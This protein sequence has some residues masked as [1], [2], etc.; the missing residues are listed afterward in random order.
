[1]ERVPFSLLRAAYEHARDT[2]HDNINDASLTL[3]DYW[4]E[5]LRMALEERDDEVLS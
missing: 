5:C 4:P 1:M 2:W 3:R